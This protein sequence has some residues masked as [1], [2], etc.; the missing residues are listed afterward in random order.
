MP[1]P[2]E[3]CGD[4]MPLLTR[5]QKISL[6]TTSP[7]LRVQ[8]LV[9]A[10]ALTLDFS[11]FGVDEQGQLSD[12]RFFIFY[13]QKQSPNGAVQLKG[14]GEFELDLERLP[15]TI[16]K[17]VFVVTVDGGGELFQIARGHFA[18][19]SQE[20][21]VAR[22]EFKGSD[23]GREK[24]IM[25]AEIY[26]RD[27]WRM[28]AVG[29]GFAG[30]LDAVLQH[31]GGQQVEAPTPNI[32]DADEEGGVIACVRCGK[33][34]PTWVE[35][36]KFNRDTG[37]CTHC[38]EEVQAALEQLRRDFLVASS[39]GV[40]QDAPWQ[41]MWKRFDCARQK[42]SL[43]EALVFLRPDALQFVERLFTMSA[44]DGV[45]TPAEEK[46]I[47]QMLGAL[48]IPGELQRPIKARLNQFK[49]LSRIR[50]GYLPTVQS[51]GHHLDADEI[52]HLSVP[53]TFRKVLLR[54]QNE[55]PGTLLATN[56]RLFFAPD[57]DSVWVIRYKNIFQ[58]KESTETIYLGLSGG[59]GNG[60]YFVPDTAH[61]EAVVTTLTL[62][63]KRLLLGPQEEGL[64]RRIPQEVRVAVWQRDGGKC[65]E[66]G[67]QTYLEFDH[68]IP[69]SKGG[70]NTVG[71]VQLLC[72]KCNLAKGSRL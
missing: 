2:R 70:A 60:H 24:A 7:R 41:S 35:L 54:P 5:G 9:Q 51:A 36:R 44:A 3:F 49:E 10:P 20:N 47:K 29:Q 17:L 31:F 14:V 33:R 45:V 62:M 19:L 42:V 11:C 56:K 46:Y 6:A 28:A 58:I 65:R 61:A 8:C 39:S 53:A 25:M 32:V 68:E 50:G 71:N 69:H 57:D 43:E 40:L 12:D 72:R 66:C 23:F 67:S 22:F 15:P 26:R 27:G 16:H 18:L 38:D 52:C 59:K 34:A 30:G 4:F 48:G 1:K 63:A 13:N 21:E 55:V 37:R 64:S